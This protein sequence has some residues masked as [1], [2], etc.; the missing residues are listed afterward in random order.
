VRIENTVETPI[1]AICMQA[2]CAISW[3][4]AIITI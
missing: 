4:D 2:G 3:L 1:L